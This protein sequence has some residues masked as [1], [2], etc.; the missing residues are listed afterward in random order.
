MATAPRISYPDGSG[1][2]TELS[3]TTNVVGLSFVGAVDPNTVDVQIDLNGAGFTSDPTLVGLAPPAFSIPNP[4]SF[5]NGLTLERGRNTVRIRAVDLDGS[6]SAASTITVNVVNDASALSEMAPPTG[7]ELRRRAATVDVMWSDESTAGA[8][9]YNVYASVGGGGTSSGYLRVNAA[10]IPSSAVR[11]VRLD[12]VPMISFDYDFR[13]TNTDLEFQVQTQTADAVTG[14]VS[15]KKSLTAW[16]LFS[17]PDFRFKGSIVRLERVSQYVY[18]HDRASDAGSGVLNNDAFSSVHPDDPLFYVVAAVYYDRSTG[19]LTESRYS[20]EVSGAPLP[21][22]TTVRGIR[23]RDQRKIAESYIDEVQRGDP[24]LSLIPGSTVREVHIETFANEMQKAYFLMDFVARAKSFPALLA[25]DDPTLSGTSVLVSNSAYKQNLRTALA[26]SDDAAVQALVDGAFESLARNYGVKRGGSRL[27]VV[28]QT[29]WTAARP[30]R[31]LTVQQNAVVSSSRNATAPRFRALG[32]A[33]MLAANAQ[34]YYNPDKRRYEMTLQ[35]VAE[36]PGSDGNAPAGD[37]DTVVS[38]ANGLQTVNEVSADQGRDTQSN[39]ELA[40]TAMRAITGVDSGTTGG[41][42]RTASGTPGVFEARVVA[43]GDDHMVRDWDPV[44]QRHTG[45]KVDIWVKGTV[46]RTIDETFAFQFSSARSVRFDVIDAASLVLR[47]RDSRLSPDNPI[48]ELL[49]NPSQGLG[50]RNH[51][52]LPTASYDLTGAEMMDYQTIRLSTLIPQPETRLDD[53]VEGDYRYRSNNRFTASVQPV[54]RVVSVT[55]EVSGTLN[56]ASGYL[57]YKT[58]DPLDAGESTA[59]SDYVSIVQVG[60]VPSGASIQVNAEEH[61]MIGEYE[62]PLRFVGANKFTLRVYSRDRSV[63]YNGPEAES[64][65][66]FVIDGTQTKPARIVRS[67][68]SAIASG[69][70]VSL[71]YEHDENFKVTYVV[72]DVLHRVQ[73]RV[74]RSRHAGADVLVKQAVENPMSV[75]ATVQLAKNAVQSSVDS[76]IRTQVSILTDRKGI[77]ESVHQTDYST[78]M[79]TSSSG[80]SFI[81]QPFAKMTLQD[82]SVRIRDGMPPDATFLSSLSR[83][84][85]A[86]YVLDEPLPFS[87]ADGGGPANV[88]RGV[89]RDKLPLSLARSLESVGDRPDQ[90]W[91][92]GGSGA[93]VYGYSDDDTLTAAVGAA[94]VAAERLRRTANKVFVSLRLPDAPSDH[95][96]AATYVVSGDRGVMDIDVSQVEYVTPGELTLTYREG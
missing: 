76:A 56:P 22:D 53:F 47:A 36:S 15:S 62:E 64:P 66:Y 10:M 78:A 58:Q 77:G 39:L 5:P 54:R 52:V 73:S 57:L 7:I 19:L 21:L 44:R 35:L 87:T 6:V 88:H 59:A 3:L 45:G 74:D 69:A 26:I 86:V 83:F 81:V 51:S 37:L 84:D 68:A 24:S 16:P 75:E 79:K 82:G 42:L 23:I 30:T 34:S 11:E 29:F 96:W 70:T 80:V 89:Y 71:D 41:Y 4:V 94:G 14:E 93:V 25:I 18:N 95:E 72:N 91:I 9:G 49:D 92:V 28:Q 32:S 43:A 12:E 2:T 17:S 13:E 8:A 61:V 38:G 31:D 90:A 55:G 60:D 85:N 33:T 27:A 50:F 1:M 20:R 40:E 63:L 65:D 48:Q 67:S 46:E